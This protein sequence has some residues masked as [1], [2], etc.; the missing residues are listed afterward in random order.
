[1]KKI[2]CL[3]AGILLFSCVSCNTFPTFITAGAFDDAG[4]ALKK[5]AEIVEQEVKQEFDG[6]DAKFKVLNSEG[7]IVPK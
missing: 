3:V 1:M 4:A 6:F 2:L 5:D 7:N